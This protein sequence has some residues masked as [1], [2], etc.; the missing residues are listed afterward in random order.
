VREG[1]IQQDEQHLPHTGRVAQQ[2]AAGGAGGQGHAAF[3]G[4]PAHLPEQIGQQVGH[5]ERAALQGQ[6]LGIEPRQQ[7]QVVDQAAHVVAL[8]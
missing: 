6:G 8:L 2:G 5:P 4:Q 1:V 7:Q 3:I